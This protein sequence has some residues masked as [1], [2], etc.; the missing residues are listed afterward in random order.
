MLPSMLPFVIP[1]RESK[2]SINDLL[3]CCSHCKFLSGSGKNCHGFY[4][5]FAK[6]SVGIQFHLGDRGSTDQGSSIYTYEDNLLRTIIG[7]I[8]YVED[9]FLHGVPKKIVSD[10][11]T[12]FTLKF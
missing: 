5:G 10:R 7:I 8:V 2:L 3:D 12:Q 4:H 6:N 9:S 11:G 1:V